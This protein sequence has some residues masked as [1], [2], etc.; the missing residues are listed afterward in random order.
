MNIKKILSGIMASVI[1]ISTAVTAFAAGSSTEFTFKYMEDPTYTITIPAAITIDKDG[2]DVEV[3]ASDVEN[4][5][6]QKISVT[7]AGT[8]FYRNQF[9]LQGNDAD[10]KIKQVRYALTSASG[11]YMETIGTFI[12]QHVGKELVSFTED[13]TV[14]YNITPLIQPNTAKGVAFT[15]T[16]TYGIE[17]V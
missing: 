13:G 15:G 5:G 2:T 12:D 6:D 16:L 17:L 10:N 14:S 3:V 8:N 4:L 9:V 1:V 11:E 7:V